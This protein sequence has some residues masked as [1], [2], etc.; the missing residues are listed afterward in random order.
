M[1]REQRQWQEQSRF[2]SLA[3]QREQDKSRFQPY[4]GSLEAEAKFLQ[5][6]EL[7]ALLGLDVQ[8]GVPPDTVGD[9][10]VRVLRFITRGTPPPG[11]TRGW[12]GDGEEGNILWWTR[13][14]RNDHRTHIALGWGNHSVCDVSLWEPIDVVKVIQLGYGG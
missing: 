12:D 3:Q 6:V 1:N 8:V 10:D 14:I 4:L 2:A 7:C 11:V 13:E 9:P 5:V